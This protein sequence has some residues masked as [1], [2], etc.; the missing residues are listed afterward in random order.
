MCKKKEI[1]IYKTNLELRRINK[2]HY[3]VQIIE[4]WIIRHN[5]RMLYFELILV[6]IRNV[7][8]ECYNAVVFRVRLVTI[9]LYV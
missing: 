2:R 8:W 7:L 6:D 9:S 3:V 1:W 5:R 4:I